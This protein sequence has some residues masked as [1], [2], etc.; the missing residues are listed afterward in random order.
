MHKYLTLVA[1]AAFVLTGCGST[2]ITSTRIESALAPTFANLVHV[3][4]SWLGLPPMATSEFAVKASCRRLLAGTNTGSGEWA[5]ALVWRGP[6]R[7]T[8]RDTY[9]LFVTPDGCY[10]ATASAENVGGPTLKAED[11]SQ[12]RNLLYVFERM[13]RYD[14]TSGGESAGRPGNLAALLEERVCDAHQCEAV[15]DRPPSGDI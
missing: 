7:R 8:V 1:L 4:M 2:P 14:V 11:G 3:Q 9:E 12:V 15:G 10:T 13:L 6:D 5:C